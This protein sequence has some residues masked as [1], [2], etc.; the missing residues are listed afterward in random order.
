MLCNGPPLRC[1]KALSPEVTTMTR[2]T[3]SLVACAILASGLLAS[4]GP[5]PPPPKVAPRIV[6]APP[7][8]EQMKRLAEEVYVYAYPLVLMDVRRQVASG[9]APVNTFAHK[10][11][12]PDASAT[13]VANPDANMLRSTAW[14]DLSSEPIVLSVPDTHGRYYLM[15]MQDAWTNVFASP[16]KRV[17]GTDKADFAI[18][19]PRWKGTLPGGVEEIKSPTDMVWV[20]GRTQVNGKGDVAA[21]N[22]IQ[23]QYKLTPLS[24]WSKTPASRKPAAAPAQ[25][26][27]IDLKTL[28]AEQVAKMDARTFFTR[29]AELLA[30]NP[31]TKDDAPMVEKMKKLG[32]VAGQPFDLS[33][34]DA[35]ALEGINGAPKATQDAIVAAAK[36][37]GGAEIRNG[38]TF[39]LDLGRYGTNY[40]KRAFVAWLGLDSDAPEDE[41]QMSTRLDGGGK[42]LD[43]ANKYVLHF[44]NSKTAPSDA[45]W[46]VTLYNEKKLLAANAIERYAIGDRDK[47]TANPDGSLDIFIQNTNPGA[48]KESNWLPAPK[49]SFNLV[50]R[51]YWPRQ[52]VLAGRWT[53]PPLRPVT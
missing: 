28:P 4:C 8:N 5:E 26:A 2:M 45:G 43:G 47:L 9:K 33:K 24:R 30:G 52:D 25:A 7:V 23:D 14:L 36:G 31:P 20:D 39:H 13:D 35:P 49:G 6:V 42:P 10:R 27:R 18:V 50:L 51:V 22:K 16:G 40:G 41:I 53:P 34:L 1:E 17:T 11:A 15:S 37:T 19:G 3:Q 29:F 12:L 32:I 48:G 38:W 44:D 21:V 46:S